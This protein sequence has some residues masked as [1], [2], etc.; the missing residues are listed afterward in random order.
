MNTH[1]SGILL[2]TLSRWNILPNTK[3]ENPNTISFD[4]SVPSFKEV[5]PT[6]IHQIAL[7]K[8]VFVISELPTRIKSK[9]ISAI[10]MTVVQK[11]T[12]FVYRN[13][14]SVFDD[15]VNLSIDCII[16]KVIRPVII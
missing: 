2:L 1:R 11:I 7:M 9:I 16:K 4:E 3:A 6:E 5:R 14:C 8:I 15:P 13:K 10:A 12:F